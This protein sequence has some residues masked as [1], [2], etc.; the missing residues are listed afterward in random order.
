MEG[1]EAYLK[2]KKWFE[3]TRIL[4]STIISALGGIEILVSW[5]TS[6]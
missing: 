1:R 2:V 5:H 4:K 3:T 6:K